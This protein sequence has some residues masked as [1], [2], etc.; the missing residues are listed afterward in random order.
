MHGADMAEPCLLVPAA[1]LVVICEKLSLGNC[2]VARG[3]NRSVTGGQS[4]TALT[5][6][7]ERVAPT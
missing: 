4:R 2:G 1:M 6:A 7:N 5:L 3:W